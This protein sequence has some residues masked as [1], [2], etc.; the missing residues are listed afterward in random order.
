MG[1]GAP[2]GNKNRSKDKLVESAFRRKFAQNP[3]DADFIA[4][5]MINR[6]KNGDVSAAIFVRDT[7]DGKPVKKIDVTTELNDAL[8]VI[9]SEELRAA[10]RTRMAPFFREAL[11]SVEGSGDSGTPSHSRVN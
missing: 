11:R 1:V 10:V 7:V 8:A 2:V 5:A 4:E 3:E 6:A 9:G